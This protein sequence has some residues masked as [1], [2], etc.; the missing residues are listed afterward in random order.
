L[1]KLSAGFADLSNP[2]PPARASN[3]RGQSSSQPVQWLRCAPRCG[4]LAVVLG[5]D[6][7]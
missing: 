5:Y 3:H 2:A 4:Q 7:M 6:G 1:R